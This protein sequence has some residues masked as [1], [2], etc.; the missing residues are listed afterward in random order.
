MH[1]AKLLLAI[2]LVLGIAL[3]S[4]IE[5]KSLEARHAVSLNDEEPVSSE[6]GDSLAGIIPELENVFVGTETIDGEVVA[7]YQEV[8]VYKDLEGNVLKE[9]PTPNYNYIRYHEN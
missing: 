8:E 6:P 4:Y 2:P 1:K 7:K 5:N 3:L 9:V